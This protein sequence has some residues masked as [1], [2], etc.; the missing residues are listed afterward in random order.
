MHGEDLCDDRKRNFVRAFRSKVQTDGGVQPRGFKA[1]FFEEAMGAVDRSEDADV[2]G[3]LVEEPRKDGLIVGERVGHEHDG[4][5]SFDRDGDSGW[6][7]QDGIGGWE[8]VGLGVGGAA[9]DDGDVPSDFLGDADEGDGVVAGA[10]DDEGEW[11]R[12][13]FGEKR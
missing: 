10:E 5:V 9:V 3:G 8:A 4:G 1:A 2:S 6:G 11:G 13:C 12:D 7:D